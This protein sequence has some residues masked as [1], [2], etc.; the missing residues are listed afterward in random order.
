MYLYEFVHS[1]FINQ[2]LLLTRNLKEMKNTIKIYTYLYI[3]LTI[4]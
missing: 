3:A 1:D 2:Y 4:Y